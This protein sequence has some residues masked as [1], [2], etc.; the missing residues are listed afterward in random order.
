VKT[1]FV[2]K[3]RVTA[4]GTKYPGSNNKQSGVKQQK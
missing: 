2:Q 1:G 3:Q 4:I